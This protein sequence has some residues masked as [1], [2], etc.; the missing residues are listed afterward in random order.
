MAHDLAGIKHQ[1]DD[2]SVRIRRINGRILDQSK[3]FLEI[4]NRQTNIEHRLSNLVTK[5]KSKSK[6]KN[7]QKHVKL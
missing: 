5:K 7:N 2:H 6:V 3:W 4:S 1:L